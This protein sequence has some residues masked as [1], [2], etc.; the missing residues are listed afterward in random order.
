[1]RTL[2]KKLREGVE[3]LKV[4]NAKALTYQSNMMGPGGEAGVGE[5]GRRRQKINH[6]GDR[7][8]AKCK[9][10]GSASHSRRT[11]KQCPLNPKNRQSQ[12]M[13]TAVGTSRWDVYIGHRS[14]LCKLTLRACTLVLTFT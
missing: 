7:P 8:K 11:S 4:D 9:H 13:E 5:V 3:K 10:C 6:D 12:A 14:V 2:Y 1:M